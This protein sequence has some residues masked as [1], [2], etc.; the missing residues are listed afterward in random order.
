MIACIFE[1]IR[2]RWALNNFTA[3]GYGGIEQ[4]THDSMAM[5][6]VCQGRIPASLA[7]SRKVT[8]GSSPDIPCRGGRAGRCT[9]SRRPASRR[10]PSTA[11]RPPRPPAN[12]QTKQ[13]VQTNTQQSTQ[14]WTFHKPSWLHYCLVKDPTENECEGEKARHQYQYGCFLQ[15]GRTRGPSTT[16][17]PKA[18]W[19]MATQPSR[20][21]RCSPA[22]WSCTPKWQTDSICSTAP[23]GPENAVFGSYEQLARPY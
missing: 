7:P 9:R 1:H 8:A 10:W 19:S 5:G 11:T 21:A 22:H 20:A 3:H 13:T 6:F 16:S 18:D 12:N 2:W 14:R 23:P 17:F 4:L 15:P